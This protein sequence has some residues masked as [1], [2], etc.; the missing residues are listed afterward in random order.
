[1]HQAFTNPICSKQRIDLT[2]FAFSD[3]GLAG[4]IEHVWRDT[5]VYLDNNDPIVIGRAYGRVSRH[6]LHEELLRR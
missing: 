1:M 4:C 3:L 2:Q 6:L 5:I